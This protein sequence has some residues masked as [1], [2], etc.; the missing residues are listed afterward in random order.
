MEVTDE[1]D[2]RLAPAV[3]MV[4]R[5]GASSFE[6]RFSDDQVPIVWMAIAEY[7]WLDGLPVAKGTDGA[8]IRHETAA[9]LNPLRAVFRL[10]EQLIDGGQCAHCGRPTAFAED[11]TPTFGDDTICWTQYDPELKTFRRAC[12]GES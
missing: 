12:E 6:M 11:L 7:H 8:E 9:A 2:E 4:R 5:T 10:L 3:D 1:Y